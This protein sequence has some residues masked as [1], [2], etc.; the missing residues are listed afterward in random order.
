MY[1]LVVELAA[2]RR[3]DPSEF[4]RPPARSVRRRIPYVEGKAT[5]RCFFAPL[6]A[7]MDAR[8]GPIHD[9]V[10]SME[11]GLADGLTDGSGTRSVA[12]DHTRR[13]PRQLALELEAC[14][15]FANYHYIL[16]EDPQVRDRGGRRLRAFSSMLELSARIPPRHSL[17][18][19]EVRVTSR[20]RS[21]YALG[22]GNARQSDAVRPHGSNLV[23]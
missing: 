12:G 5:G 11:L 1:N 19:C 10:L 21:E 3:T 4:S 8:S 15:K 13:G 9:L 23:C 16:F 22:R 14:V 17:G 20:S 6:L 2:G 18:V 7:E